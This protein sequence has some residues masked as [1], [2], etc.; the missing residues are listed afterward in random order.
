[1]PHK[2]GLKKS[3]NKKPDF[4][5]GFY[6]YYWDNYDCKSFLPVNFSLEIDYILLILSIDFRYFSTDRNVKFLMPGLNFNF[7]Y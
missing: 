2:S 1:M 7:V 5:S 4:D 6:C 3:R